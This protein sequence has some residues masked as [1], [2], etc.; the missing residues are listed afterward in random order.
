M[1]SGVE[2]NG[3][4]YHGIDISD[5]NNSLKENVYVDGTY[6]LCDYKK[7]NG[8]K[9]YACDD[10]DYVFTIINGKKFKQSQYSK[11]DVKKNN[12]AQKYFQE[13]LEL[14]NNM[15]SYGILE[16]ATENAVDSSGNYILNNANNNTPIN[17]KYKIFDDN[18]IE[19]SNS[20]FNRH[21]LEVIRYSIEKNLSIAI[22][23]YNNY[24]HV[25][26]DFQ[27]PK[28]KEYEWDSILNNVSVISFLQGLNIGG[29]VYNGYA[30]VNNNKNE[31][32]V[33][34]DS[35]YIADGI[36]N[37]NTYYKVTDKIFTESSTSW[38]NY[39]GV[40]NVD[41]E[42][43]S[44]EREED[45]EVHYYYPNASLASYTSIVTNS[46]IDDRYQGDIYS[47]LLEDSSRK[48]LASIYFTALARERYSMYKVDNTYEKIQEIMRN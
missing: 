23:N 35:I 17:S 26:T 42:I 30:I 24:S 10:I 9:Y 44:A 36:N 5:E 6:K 20:N 21:R 3:L 22:A 12:N 38:N 28:L 7:V 46:G 25:T 2:N 34:E 14:K 15:R 13:A 4:T 43:K 1:L 48:E 16:L 47:Y 19:K 45:R 11:D 31:E 41:F 27:M 18:N 40:F 39:R 33:T 8:V 37:S 32:V 29:K